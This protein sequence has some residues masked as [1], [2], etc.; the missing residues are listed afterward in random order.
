MLKKILC[1]KQNL[2]Y[3]VVPIIKIGSEIYTQFLS[4][5]EEVGRKN[6]R[7]SWGNGLI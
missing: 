6:V 7:L 4:S 1:F 5:R 3:F 2:Q